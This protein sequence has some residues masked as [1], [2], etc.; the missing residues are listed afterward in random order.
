M[1]TIILLLREKGKILYLIL[2]GEE[3]D[4]KYLRERPGID[5]IFASI[6]THSYSHTLFSRNRLF[7]YKNRKHID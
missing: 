2:V 4:W 5:E 7:K 6:V 1:L 3:N